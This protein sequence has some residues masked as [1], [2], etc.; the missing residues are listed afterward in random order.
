[1]DVKNCKICLFG[2]QGSGKSF[3]AENYLLDKFK[4]P[5]VYLM[6]K[7]DFQRR[8]NHVKAI[9]PQDEHGNV[10][11]SA[12]TLN[13]W[14]KKI[15]EWAIQGKT[16]AFVIDEADLFIPKDFRGLQKYSYFHDIIINHR[17]YNLSIIFITRRPQ[18]LP[19][20]IT[21]QSAHYFI[22]HIAGKNVKE[23]L[24]R[25]YDNL[26]YLASQLKRKDYKFIHLEF[27]EDK[28]LTIYNAIKPKE[29]SIEIK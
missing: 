19:T 23:H 17:H 10:D 5:V 6:H 25:I 13:Q 2:L 22:F 20:M 11:T 15:K 1:M 28:P 26:G 27:G 21:E 8:G 7:E 3:F 9:I 29:K 14:S 16:D 4:Y 12:K 18:E 24:N